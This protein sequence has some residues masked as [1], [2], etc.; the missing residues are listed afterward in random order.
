MFIAHIVFQLT[1]YIS[2]QSVHIQYRF[3]TYI[4]HAFAPSTIIV[5]RRHN[6]IRLIQT[7]PAEN[8][9]QYKI[10]IAYTSLYY[11][12]MCVCVCLYMCEKIDSLLNM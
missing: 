9:I 4:L 2:S 12:C 1:K 6:E 5:E 7:R 10:H 11:M 3:E 8:F